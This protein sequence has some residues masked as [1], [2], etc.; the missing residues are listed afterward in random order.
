M[1]RK[2]LLLPVGLGLAALMGGGVFAFVETPSKQKIARSEVL[3]NDGDQAPGLANA[4]KTRLQKAPSE[5]ELQDGPAK[6]KLQAIGHA[7][8]CSETCQTRIV[9]LLTLEQDLTSAD[10]TLIT[11]NA[12]AFAQILASF[13][14]AL[15]S[16]LRR[17]QGDED[18]DNNAHLAAYAVSSALSDEDR[19]SAG[20]ALLDHQDPAYR[21]TGVKLAAD[22]V[23]RDAEAAQAFHALVTREAD[24][25]V[26]ITVLNA[27]PI[28]SNP[29]SY[30]PETIYTLDSLI[31]T[32]SSDYIRGSALV[33]KSKLVLSPADA[34]IDVKQAL[35]SSS[36]AFRGYGLQAYAIMK[37]REIF[38]EDNLAQ[39]TE[40]QEIQEL[41][42]AMIDDPEL[43]SRD[44]ALAFSLAK[45]F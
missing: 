30:Q 39:L 10:V 24:P 23:T 2:S 20:R 37:D 13:P 21:I 44:R 7:A 14:N 34:R 6:P 45:R 25:Q 36:G 38:V 8:S 42:N 27:L 22:A 16:L 15:G 1:E 12:E 26:L 43:G 17:L 4:D 29:Q 35:R 32:Q 9:E 40:D 33:A 19:I 3:L 5:L 41:L 18:G 31:G 28:I 11:D